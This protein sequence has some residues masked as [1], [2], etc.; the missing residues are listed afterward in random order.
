VKDKE[1]LKVR[2]VF[3]EDSKSNIEVADLSSFLYNLKVYY[4][5]LEN[6][7]DEVLS[8]FSIE[9][10]EW[11][12]E[13]LESYLLRADLDRYTKYNLFEENLSSEELEIAEIHKESP[14]EIVMVGTEVFLAIALVISGGEIEFSP[15]DG[16]FRVMMPPLGEGIKKLKEGLR[17]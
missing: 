16:S 6:N 4:T 15:E 12:D 7:E 14:L 13:L 5:Y 11:R 8:E 3:L 1:R 2:A 10:I 17:H 9:D